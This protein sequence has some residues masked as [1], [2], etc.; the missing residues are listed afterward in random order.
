MQPITLCSACH[1]RPI[2]AWSRPAE[3]S[4]EAYINELVFASVEMS[5]CAT[6]W[7]K[8]TSIL[9]FLDKLQ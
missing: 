4:V 2:L 7:E 5:L 8:K 6:I 9:P 1:R 3:P